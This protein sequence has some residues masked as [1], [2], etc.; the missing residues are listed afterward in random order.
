M[1][2]YDLEDM[3]V[4]RRKQTIRLME[5]QDLTKQLLQAAERHD[6]VSVQMLLS[7]RQEP[8]MQLQE[9]EDG[10]LQRLREFPEEDAIRMNELLYGGAPQN[11][12]EKALTEQVA[13]YRR[14]LESVVELDK[15][16]SIKLGGRR[17][18]YNTYRDG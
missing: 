8:V 11:A 4:R 2:Q 17:S 10:I 18:F 16:L 12:G 13:Q 6:Q 5:T 14:L 15:K 1:E 7:M 9:L 3:R